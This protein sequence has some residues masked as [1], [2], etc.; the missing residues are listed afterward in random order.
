MKSIAVLVASVL[1]L[2]CLLLW[3]THES[4]SLDLLAVDGPSEAPI[5]SDTPLLE[6]DDVDIERV[7]AQP[8]VS[9]EEPPR[10]PS[11]PKER[12]SFLTFGPMRHRP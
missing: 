3:F 11:W 7:K 5:P 6:F 1:V 4:G 2:V 8:P 9:K 12:Q 10:S